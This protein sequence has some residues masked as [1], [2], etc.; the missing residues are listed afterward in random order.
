MTLIFTI[1]QSL[2]LFYQ[3]L[4]TS[5]TYHAW[6]WGFIGLNTVI[7]LVF[8]TAGIFSCRPVSY[9]WDKAI[10]GGSCVNLEKAYLVNAAFTVVTDVMALLLPV[11][12]VWNMTTNRSSK[13]QLGALMMFGFLYER[14]P[15]AQSSDLFAREFTELGTLLL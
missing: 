7:W 10:P 8:F 12:V 3:R 5:R 11:R 6:C 13:L 9:F 15:H 1:K 14:P 2:L 4:T